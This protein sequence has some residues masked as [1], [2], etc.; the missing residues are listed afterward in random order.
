MTSIK[1][2]ETRIL[3]LE[4]AMSTI[5]KVAEMVEKHEAILKGGDSD[6]E[7]GILERVRG[8]EGSINIASGWLKAVALLFLAQFVAVIFGVVHFFIKITPVLL[9]LSK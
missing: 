7:K 3:E 9:E 2:H 6:N 5:A 4:K 1:D 8:I